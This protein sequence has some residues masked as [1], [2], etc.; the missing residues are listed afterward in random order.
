MTTPAKLTSGRCDHRPFRVGGVGGGTAPN[1]FNSHTLYFSLP[2][3]IVDLHVHA[4][5][6]TIYVSNLLFIFIFPHCSQTEI[7]ECVRKSV[8]LLLSR[9]MSSKLV[10]YHLELSDEA[11]FLFLLK[12]VCL[13][14]SKV[15]VSPSLNWYRSGST[16]ITWRNPSSL[17]RPSSLRQQSRST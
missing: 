17:W 7:D 6:K 11:L 4:F 9:T 10:V 16:P 12:A 8:N 15:R 14:W 1:G 2:L 13:S 5:S 3:P